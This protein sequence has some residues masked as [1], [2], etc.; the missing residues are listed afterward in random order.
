MWR[1]RSASHDV[2]VQLVL[3][4]VWPGVACAVRAIVAD[5][6]RLAV[7]DAPHVRDGREGLR[8][9]EL[10][11]AAI[12]A[13][14]LESARGRLARGDGRVR[15]AREPR[16]AA[17]VI[18]MLVRVEHVAHVLE[19]ESERANARFDQRRVFFQIAV[20]QHVAFI[21]GDE[22]RAQSAGSDE[23]RVAV[24]LLR[25]RRL[26]PFRVRLGTHRW[27][28]HACTSRRAA[29][30]TA[31]GIASRSPELESARECSRAM[32]R[33]SRFLLPICGQG[34]HSSPVSARAGAASH[35]PA[36]QGRRRTSA[37]PRA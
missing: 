12:A 18:G 37:A 5:A 2:Q 15:V 29:A 3:P 36:T 28:Q 10:R 14:A 13:P 32:R 22:Y 16:D 7:G 6:D 9:K 24:D 4:A 31:K 26:G 19:P 20:D 25:R 1:Q 11:I 27:S 35:R 33:C 17:G 8:R 30:S 23:I 21:R 34:R